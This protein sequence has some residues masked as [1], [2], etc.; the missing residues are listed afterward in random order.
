[1][2]DTWPSLLNKIRRATSP[3][4]RDMLLAAHEQ[5]F[6]VKVHRNG[7]FRV[8]A[9]TD[10]TDGTPPSAVTPGTPSDSRS[11]AN[12]RSELRRIGVRFTSAN[13]RSKKRRAA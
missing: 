4:I 8:T 9:P 11:I 10:G 2:A 12:T 3:E 13:P 1:M 7:H 6:H 5:G